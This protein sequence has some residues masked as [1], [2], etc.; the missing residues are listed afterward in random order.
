MVKCILGLILAVLLAS[1]PLAAQVPGYPTGC[2]RCGV[3]S[4]IDWIAPTTE[5]LTIAGWAFEC[6][7]GTPADRVDVFYRADSGYFVPV[8]A[9]L[10]N[11]SI[12]RPDVANAFR[13]A[14]ATPDNAGF[15][16]VIDGYLPS[17][18][19]DVAI[20]VWRGPY[21]NTHIRAIIVP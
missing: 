3:V 2:P 20:N 11:F 12:Y 10:L 21:V 15:G 17:G 16:T 8:A 9:H 14:C 6:Q 1:V 18:A 4:Y 5:G 13:G 7:G 19:R